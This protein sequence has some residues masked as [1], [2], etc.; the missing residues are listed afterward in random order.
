MKPYRNSSALSKFVKVERKTGASDQYGNPLW[1]TFFEAFAQVSDRIG[2]ETLITSQEKRV[3]TA[4]TTFT[5]RANQQSEAITP[6]MQI[7]WH[8]FAHNI[9]SG[10]IFSD[11][12]N[13]V[14]IEAVRKY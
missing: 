5:F 10:P 6:A 13:F 11:D 14:I 1:E 9:I 2:S 4:K 8:G 7:V 12:R 3:S